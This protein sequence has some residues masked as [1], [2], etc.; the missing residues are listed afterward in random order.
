M[1]HEEKECFILQY[2][3][4]ICQAHELRLA[5]LIR[6]LRIKET[7]IGKAQEYAPSM[8]RDCLCCQGKQAA[9]VLGDAFPLFTKKKV[10]KANYLKCFPRGFQ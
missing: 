5:G 4:E 1:A 10:W 9:W 3:I 7:S 6:V 8:N 2:N